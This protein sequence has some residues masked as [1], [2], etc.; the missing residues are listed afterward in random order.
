MNISRQA[1]RASWL[2]SLSQVLLIPALIFM[3]AACGT[4]KPI[5]ETEGWSP[6]RLYEEAKAEMDAANYE[7]AIQLLEKLESRY[8]YGRYAQQAQIDTAFAYYKSGDNAQAL[9]ATERFI[10]LYPNHQNLDYVYYLR[11]LISFNEDKGIFTLLSG[12]DQSARDP[13]GTRAAF[14]AFK[15]VVTRFPDSKYYDDSRSRLQYLVNSLAQNELHVARYYYK[16]GA[17]LAAVNRSQEVIKRF[18]QTPSIEEA[19]F[20]SLRCYEKLGM[21]KLAEDTKRVID[22]NFKNSPYW[23]QELPD[24]RNT[25]DAQWWQVWKN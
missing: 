5:D 20:I 16:R 25:T 7:R 19:L 8:P 2:R 15:E 3:L 9:A 18:E 22:L 4:G 17:Y 21:T 13:K 24:P 12:E 14:D 23:K 6:A 10:K 11:G 1:P